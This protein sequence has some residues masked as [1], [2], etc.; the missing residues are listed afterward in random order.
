[1]GN[2]KNKF[3]QP[4]ETAADLDIPREDLYGKKRSDGKGN[5][6]IRALTVREARL[7]SSR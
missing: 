6:Q 5:E 2:S 1:M 4:V 3:N 7:L